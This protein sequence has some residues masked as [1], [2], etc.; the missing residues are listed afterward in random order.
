MNDSQ[1]TPVWELKGMTGSEPGLLSLANRVLSFE[2]EEGV[3]FD[4]P[5]SQ[6]KDVKW[7]W[8]SFGAALNLTANGTKY[9]FSFA[10]PN[11]AGAAWIPRQAAAG[12][13]DLGNAMKTGKTWKAELSRQLG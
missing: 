4:C 7:P 1:Q 8:Y 6:L 3:R 11:G 13:L 10:R 9:R 5:V 12:I 2:T